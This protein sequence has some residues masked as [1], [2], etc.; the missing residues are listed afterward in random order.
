VKSVTIPWNPVNEMEHSGDDVKWGTH[1][2][3]ESSLQSKEEVGV[4]RLGH[5][6][7]CAVGQNQVVS[8]NGVD[9]KTVLVGFIGVPCR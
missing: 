6:D 8:D 1:E 7:D 3:V 9:G 2:V 5:I 4:V